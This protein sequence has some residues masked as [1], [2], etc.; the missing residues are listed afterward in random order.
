[1]TKMLPSKY[2]DELVQRL[3]KAAGANLE[4]VILY[5]SA[6]SGEFQPDISDINLLCV[7]HDT[8]FPALRVLMRTI[9]WWTHRQQAVPLFMTREELVHSADVFTIE[10]LDMKQRYQVLVG[11]D[12]LANLQIP[13]NLHRV[14]VEY[15]LR[16]KLLLL[17][18]RALLTDGRQR[19]LKT[20]LFESLPS[21]LTLFRHALIALGET[22][23][24]QKREAVHVL[25]RRVGLDPAPM[26]DVLNARDDKM[27][28]KQK[29]VQT[30][31]A[32]YLK[33]IEQVVAAVDR[34][35]DQDR[36]SRPAP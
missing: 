28:A 26:E 9:K 30:L 4:S 32:S 17:R 15:E 11:Q 21:F 18:Q 22:P 2:V 8:S 13:M 19:Q 16:E 36:P 35:L 1:M 14:Q 31:F 24:I 10:F 12:L 6:V 20:L 23:T 25:A 5:G 27:D 29:D 33:L 7:L 34:M 3:T